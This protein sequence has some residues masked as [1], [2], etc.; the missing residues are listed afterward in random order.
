MLFFFV[1]TYIA[2]IPGI[3]YILLITYAVLAPGDCGLHFV[4]LT[5]KLVLQFTMHKTSFLPS[6]DDNFALAMTCN[7]FLKKVYYTDLGHDNL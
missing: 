2:L 4:F 6:E 3:P 5:A 7:E 1:E